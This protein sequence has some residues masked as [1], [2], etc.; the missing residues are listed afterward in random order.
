MRITAKVKANSKIDGVDKTGEGMFHI[1][2]KA[3]AIDGK[4]NKAVIELLSEYF[5]VPKNRIVIIKG[6]KSRVKSIDILREY[7]KLKKL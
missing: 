5:N 4:A 1:S 3:P 6:R 2:V 7:V